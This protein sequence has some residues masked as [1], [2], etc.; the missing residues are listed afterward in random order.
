MF[1]LS[2][3]PVAPMIY[4]ELRASGKFYHQLPDEL[5]L[6]S[7]TSTLLRVSPATEP[8]PGH[9]ECGR[10]LVPHKHHQIHQSGPQ[11]KHSLTLTAKA[12]LEQYGFGSTSTFDQ[13]SEEQQAQRE[14]IA[15]PYDHTLRLVWIS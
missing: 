10:P 12:L 5:T 11:P 14:P 3:P 1:T 6:F 13:A 15:P 7:K 8:H 2:C 4:R 9:G